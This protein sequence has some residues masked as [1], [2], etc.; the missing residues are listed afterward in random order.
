MKNIIVLLSLE[1]L[2][3]SPFSFWKE[4]KGLND[5]WKI[6][7]PLGCVG[8]NLRLGSGLCHSLFLLGKDAGSKGTPGNAESLNKEKK[9]RMKS[10]FNLGRMGIPNP[11]QK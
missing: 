2:I 9:M 10:K 6:P 5:N 1:I 4:T 11:W 8:K 7:L 3:F